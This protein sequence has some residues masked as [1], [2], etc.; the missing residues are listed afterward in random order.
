MGYVPTLGSS[1]TGWAPITAFKLFFINTVYTQA[2]GGPET[3]DVGGVFRTG[4]GGAGTFAVP[5]WAGFS[6]ISAIRLYDAAMPKQVTDASPQNHG[7]SIPLALV[8]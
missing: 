7:K 4:E 6:G 5:D 2:A 3:P 1:S 8:Q